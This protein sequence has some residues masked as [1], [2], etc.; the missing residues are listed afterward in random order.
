MFNALCHYIE[1]KVYKGNVKF[2]R[3]RWNLKPQ[4]YFPY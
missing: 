4:K 1:M 3:L 2:V